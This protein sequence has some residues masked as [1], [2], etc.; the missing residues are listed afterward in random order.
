MN[1]KYYKI[2]DYDLDSNPFFLSLYQSLYL[3]FLTNVEFQPTQ[4]ISKILSMIQSFTT[5]ILIIGG[6]AFLFD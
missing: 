3:Q 4:T 5:F 6:I 2:P 1:R